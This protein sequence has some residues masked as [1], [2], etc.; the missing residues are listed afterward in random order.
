MNLFYCEV[1]HRLNPVV[2]PEATYHTADVAAL[3]PQTRECYGPDDV[4]LNV[5]LR[6]SYTNCMAECRSMIAYE[7]CGC[8]PF[9]MPNNGS[10]PTC[11]FDKLM[12]VQLNKNW[13]DGAYPGYNNSVLR[14]NIAEEF[15]G[16][17][18]CKA[19]CDNLQYA[20]EISTGLFTRNN[21]Y[22]A[23]SFL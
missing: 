9:L 16:R 3:S 7:R 11:E 14:D 4:K 22:N 18:K 13:W 5:F 12:C 17:C 8:V 2:H 1:N 23:R 21:S 19:D 20:T 10:Y 6:Y 15:Q